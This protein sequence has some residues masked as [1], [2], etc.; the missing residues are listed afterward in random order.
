MNQNECESMEKLTDA[1]L[2]CKINE[3]TDQYE[4]P[5]DHIVA[6]NMLG[7]HLMTCENPNCELMRY[8]RIEVGIMEK[9][10]RYIINEERT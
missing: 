8:R 3:E 2:R 4:N 7:L 6:Q 1:I 10:G 5:Q 9:D